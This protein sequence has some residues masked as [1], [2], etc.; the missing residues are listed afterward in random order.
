M[1]ELCGKIST[2]KYPLKSTTS[3][4]MGTADSASTF[5]GLIPGITGFVRAAGLFTVFWTRIF[6]PG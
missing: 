6:T 3:A 1:T 2:L 4:P 5:T